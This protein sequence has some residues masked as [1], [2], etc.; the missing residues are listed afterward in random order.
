[1]VRPARWGVV[2]LAVSFAGITSG[3]AIQGYVT[4]NANGNAITYTGAGTAQNPNIF[5]N[6]PALT[7]SVGS[8]DGQ[9]R[10]NEYPGPQ[11]GVEATTTETAI[12]APGQSYFYTAQ[13][14]ASFSD[15]ILA[16]GEVNSF[17]NTGEF[18]LTW[19]ISGTYSLANHST[20]YL[21]LQSF[22]ANTGASYDADIDLS[23][24]A[25]SGIFTNLPLT[26]YLPW[27]LGADY[28]DVVYFTAQAECVSQI[29]TD[30]LNFI[31]TATLGGFQVLDSQY[32]PI[33]GNFIIESADGID[34]FSLSA[35]LS[36]M[37]EPSTEGL[38][39]TCGI[40][41]LFFSCRANRRAGR[42]PSRE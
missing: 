23:E 25:G 5:I 9:A 24:L 30:S 37:P 32:Q 16:V 2:C 19:Y 11:L 26:V 14:Q 8:A 40:S 27:R 10:G 21:D 4:L 28:T 38:C 35:P 20:T 41:L 22:N 7:D 15:S 6:A 39:L 18:K 33:S 17:A 36:E 12:P 31:G 34:Y 1:M 3:T 13:S 42:P 29:C